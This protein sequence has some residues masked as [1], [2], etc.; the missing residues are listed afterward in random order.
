MQREERALAHA[1]RDRQERDKCRQRR[2]KGE[3]AAGHRRAEHAHRVGF[4]DPGRRQR[5]RDAA[6]LPDRVHEVQ[7]QTAPPRRQN[8]G[9]QRL[10]NALR[11]AVRK[12]AKPQQ[13][14]ECA[15]RRRDADR[16]VRRAEDGERE[17]QN[18]ATAKAIGERAAGQRA[19][20]GSKRRGDE[21]QALRERRQLEPRAQ[22]EFYPRKRRTDRTV[23]NE[24]QNSGKQPLRDVET[25]QTQ[26]ADGVGEVRRCN[27]R[28]RVGIAEN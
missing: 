3:L 7:K 8:L 13:H 4:G 19:D 22:I 20:E 10:R 5:E 28:Q 15:G 26:G 18:S 16:R 11:L 1:N 14:D 24:D 12:I 27:H 2:R 17:E 9:E 21:D 23:R 6:Q 25:R